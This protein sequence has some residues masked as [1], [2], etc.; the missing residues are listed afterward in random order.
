MDFAELMRLERHGDDRFVGRSPA[1]PWGGVYGGQIVA[2]ALRAAAAT[3][4]AGFAV[5]SLHA[6]YLRA[7]AADEPLS[8][9]VERTRDGGSFVARS[10]VA[11]QSAGTVATLA[12]GF[13]AGEAAADAQAAQ[14]PDV[15]APEE[16][17]AGGWSSAFDCRFLP[18][19]GTP[20]RVAAWM[21]LNPPVVDDPALAD[22]ALAYLADDVPADAVLRLLYPDRPPATSW[23][24]VDRSLFNHSLDHNIWFHRPAQVAAWQLQEFTCRSFVAGRGCVVGEVFDRSGSHLATV[25]QEVLVRRRR[26]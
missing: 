19:N 7:A 8:Y 23:E 26:S 13:H 15:A 14:A 6:Y 16:L 22:C 20:G 5:H 1:Y 4:A 21:R 10:V 11:R 12:A 2:Q 17:P 25:A 18:V 9:E 24:E 3:V